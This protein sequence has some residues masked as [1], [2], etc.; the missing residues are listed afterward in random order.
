MKAIRMKILLLTAGTRGDVEP[1]AALARSAGARGHQVRLGVPDHSGV[2][3]AGLDAV[4]LHIDFAQLINDQ[5][6]SPLTVATTFRTVIRP[7]IGRL[8]STAVEHI[9]SF[10]P[11]VVVYHPKVLSAPIAAN[12][13]GIPSVIVESVPSVTRTREFPAPY[14]TSV[15]LGPLNRATYQAA[16]LATLMFGR[17]LDAALKI[18]PAGPKRR[19]GTRVSMVPVSPQLLPRPR[20]WPPTVHLTGHWAGKPVTAAADTE[21]ED[22]MNSGNFVYA[23][24]GSMKAGDARGRGE[25]IIAAARRSGLHV[26]VTT[27]W[28]GLDLPGTATDGVLVRESV[29]HNQVLPRATA[30]IHHGGAGTVHAV[31]RAGVPSI[32]VPF[33]GDQPFWGNLLYRHGLAPA[34]IPYRRLDVDRLTDALGHA[35]NC[36]DLATDVGELM[37]KEDGVAV[38]VDVLENLAG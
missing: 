15:N 6:V 20:D 22:F 9:I 23:G 19:P 13:L 29:T 36:R 14:I 21:L 1:F 17:E 18:L 33:I 26:L 24:F 35:R 8:L 12:R 11:D 27:G 5:G 37:Q 32:V 7:G 34:P 4:S 25:I 16:S 10:A 28:G 31:A 30:A 3:T 38:A 2:D